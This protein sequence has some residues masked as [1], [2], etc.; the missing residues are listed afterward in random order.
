M[1]LTHRPLRTAVVAAAA[2]AVAMSVAVTGPAQ[3]TTQVSKPSFELLSAADMPPAETAWRAGPVEQGAGGDR[4]CV[5]TLIPDAG[6]VHRRFHTD[7][8]TGG[9]QIVHEAPSVREARKLTRELREAVENCAERYA[10]QYPEAEVNERDHGR[11]HAI[12]TA[13]PEFS[14][15]VNM[16]GLAR[17][18]KRVTLV[19]WGRIGKLED[20][21]VRD[22]KRTLRTAVDKLR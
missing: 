5:E 19:E 9:N 6:S 11:V 3:A 8:E 1:K 10:K 12:H 14:H 16:F 17:S 13:L 4:F 15:D 22:F 2:G 20:A 21:P 18:G 7:L